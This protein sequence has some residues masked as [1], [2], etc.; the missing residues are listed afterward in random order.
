MDQELIQLIKDL[1]NKVNIL[2]ED[3][4]RQGTIHE[5]RMNVQNSNVEDPHLRIRAPAYEVENYP[6]LIEE[7][8]DTEDDIFRSPLKEDER[9]EIVYG[10]PKFRVVNYQP[11][12]LNDTARTAVKKVDGLLYSIQQSS[13]NITRPIDQ[14]RHEQL[15]SGRTVDPDNDDD[16]IAMDSIRRLI[17]DLA[18]SNSQ[19]RVEN[20]HKSLE[21]RG[22]APQMVEPTVKPI[23]E[24]EKF[25]AILA[26]KK[27]AVKPKSSRT[28]PFRQRQQP[29]SGY[30]P[31]T[32]NILYEDRERQ[33]T[34]HE[35]RMNVQNSNVEDP[36][37]RIRAPAYEV[38]NYPELI[39]EFPDTEDDIFR[40]PLKEDERKEIVYGYPKFRVVN[41]QPPPLNDTARTAVKKVDG[42]L[43]SIQQSS[44]NITRPIDQYRHEQLRSGRTVDPDNDD[45]IIAMDSIR[46]LITDLASSISQS[47][48]ENIHKSLEFRGKAPQMVEPTV[49]PIYEEE[50]FDA[51]LATKKTAVKPKSSRTRPF[52]QRQQPAS[53]YAPATEVQNFI[54]RARNQDLNKV[55]KLLP[56][57]RPPRKVPRRLGKIDGQSMGELD[58]FEGIQYPV[59]RS[60]KALPRSSLHVPA[61]QLPPALP[62]KKSLSGL[63]PN[64][65]FPSSSQKTKDDQGIYENYHK[66]SGGTSIHSG[67][68]E[69]METELRF[70]QPTFYDPQEDW[71][72][73]PGSGSEE[74]ERIRS[75]SALQNGFLEL[76]MQEIPQVPMECEEAPVQSP[77]FWPIP[78]SV[79]LHKDST[80]S[81]QL[82][83]TAR[84]Q[85]RRLLGRYTNHRQDQGNVLTEHQLCSEKTTK[86]GIP[87]EGIEILSHPQTDNQTLGDLRREAS[88]LISKGQTTLRTMA[89][90]IGKAQAIIEELYTEQNEIMDSV[91]NSHSTSPQEFHLVERPAIE[92]CQRHSLG[93]RCG[94]L[95][96]LVFVASI[97]GLSPHQ[98]KRI[99]ECIICT[100]T[101][102]FCWSLC[103]GL[104]RKYHYVGIRE[105]VWRYHFSKITQDFRR[106][107]G[108][109][110]ENQHPP[111][112]D[113]CTYIPE[114]RGCSQQ[115]ECSNRVVNPE[116]DLRQDHLSLWNQLLVSQLD[117]IVQP[118]LL[119]TLE[120]DPTG[121]T[122]G[123][124]REVN[125]NSNNPLLEI[126]NLVPRSVEINSSTA[127]NTRSIC[128]RPRTQK[129]KVSHD[130]QQELVT[131]GMEDQRSTLETEGYSEHAI[132]LI[133]PNQREIKRRTR[134]S[135]IQQG[136]LDWL[137]TNKDSCNQ[138]TIS[139]INYLSEIYSKKRL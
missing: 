10:Y 59:R 18:S 36:H 117:P 126:S 27:T 97:R 48:V 40:S 84:Y 13:A 118:V 64:I 44:A 53:G 67:N 20:I 61:L 116:H 90:F 75:T 41:Y 88:K 139:L 26:T 82:V 6:E 125:I 112:D 132:R 89:S 74:T 46:R 65:N 131:R 105:E 25:D 92:I 122:E 28:R 30:A 43:Y 55:S 113:V 45:D 52:R 124:E 7:F 51:I 76:D 101:P 19:S 114:S 21:F 29:A 134:N 129:R 99:V 14:Y 47:R 77:T 83:E 111:P 107:I 23:Y 35:Q 123:E 120:P 16:I 81:Y 130:R 11:P 79:D 39:E 115:I 103:A 5:Q 96:L 93:D 133:D 87:S 63:R 106:Y 31:A 137:E 2:Y 71:R 4:E 135:A 49:K 60:H 78:Q 32:V 110:P 95:I 121:I 54:K 12:P 57:R 91:C 9:K 94:I 24:E 136:F 1:T 68:R 102:K 3:R 119:S 37:L 138:D 70:L 42:L 56:S 104:F 17:T 100:P 38:E 85:G 80:P 109:L 33:G 22:K 69:S 86:P 50:K 98:R 128:D 15:R 58:N 73:P 108:S 127:D 66:R 62:R 34:I 8:P 72:P